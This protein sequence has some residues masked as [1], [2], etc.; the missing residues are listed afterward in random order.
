MAIKNIRDPRRGTAS[1]DSV[2]V[3]V[4]IDSVG[5]G[6]P[7]TVRQEDPLFADIIAGKYGQVKAYIEPNIDY[8]PVISMIARQRLEAPYGEKRPSVNNYFGQL[9]AEKTSGS[10]SADHQHDLDTLLQA[11]AWE[12]SILDKRDALLKTP[13]AATLAQAKDPATW[14]PFPAAAAA[15]VELC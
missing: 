15:L 13:N 2:D 8:G 1:D 10:I 3:T 6:L 9:V 5:Q 4:D 11:S 12:Q 14:P 7:Y